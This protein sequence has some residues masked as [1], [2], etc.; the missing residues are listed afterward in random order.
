MGF[1]HLPKVRVTYSGVASTAALVIALSA[2]GAYAAN[3]VG[4]KHIAKGAV[5]TA[6]IHKNAVTTAKIKKAA[7]GPAKIK[8]GAVTAAKLANGS[9]GTDAILNA[10]I[11]S[12]KL[13]DGAVT[14]AKL[15][16]GSVAADSLADGSVTRIK[17]DAATSAD[18]AP[19]WEPIPSGKTVVGQFYNLGR[20]GTIPSYVVENINLPA[21]APVPLDYTHIGFGGVP[22]GGEALDPACTGTFSAPSAPRGHLC[23]YMGGLTGL[24]IPSVDLWE[25]HALRTH[26]FYLGFAQSAVDTNWSEWGTW[27]YTAP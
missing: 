21:S 23:V 7:V 20:S 14:A 26:A 16:N 19:P 2:G 17:L 25:D 8:N 4:T 24:N 10:A 15:A 13:A 5:T 6:K 9:V 18:I 3:L 12:F 11:T 27:A 22:V 1:M